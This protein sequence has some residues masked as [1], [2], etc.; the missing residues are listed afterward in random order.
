MSK[1][2]IK[3]TKHQIKIYESRIE[4]MVGQ[5]LEKHYGG[6]QWWVEC[7]LSTGVVSVRNQSL[8]GDYGFYIQLNR[9]LNETTPTLVMRAG[10]EIL[11]RY[12]MQ[13][14]ARKEFDIKR[15]F[16]GEAIG[17]KS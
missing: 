4:A 10:G 3:A 17:D 16:S 11:E 2:K 1:A 14:T 7:T 12:K 9:L 8:D 6:W 13:A 15:T 5:E